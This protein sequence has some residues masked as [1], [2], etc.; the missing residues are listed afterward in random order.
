MI[1][2]EKIPFSGSLRC[3]LPWENRWVEADDGVLP[4][5]SRSIVVRVEGSPEIAV[6]EVRESL[7][8][9]DGRAVQDVPY[10]DLSARLKADGQVLVIDK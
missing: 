10:A 6:A 1:S 5:F 3:Y 9:K 7:A 8:A 4:D 2:G